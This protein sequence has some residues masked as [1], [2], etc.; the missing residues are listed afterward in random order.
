MTVLD[1]SA[2]LALMHDESG[3]DLVAREVAGSI[4]GAANLAEVV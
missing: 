2:L 1:A 3:A 4:L